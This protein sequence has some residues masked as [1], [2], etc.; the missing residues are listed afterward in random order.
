ML[1]KKIILTMFICALYTKCSFSTQITLPTEEEITATMQKGYAIRVTDQSKEEGTLYVL[2][3]PQLWGITNPAI[4]WRQMQNLDNL[5]APASEWARTTFCLKD[6]PEKADLAEGS[7]CPVTKVALEYTHNSSKKAQKVEFLALDLGNVFVTEKPYRAT[8]LM[9]SLY[10]LLVDCKET[11]L[12]VYTQKDKS[13]LE[14]KY[15][16]RN[17]LGNSYVD[18]GNS[19]ALAMHPQHLYNISLD[20]AT[21]SHIAQATAVYEAKKCWEDIFKYEMIKSCEDLLKCEAKKFPGDISKQGFIKLDNSVKQSIN[22]MGLDY[23]KAKGYD[24]TETYKAFQRNVFFGTPNSLAT[25][26]KIVF[27]QK[28]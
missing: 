3:K 13:P 4:R 8:N 16:Y 19:I 12:E 22:V 5:I 10:K 2:A 18:L 20:S 14:L 1:Y 7:I 25:D 21:F 28:I 24:A 6:I 23:V 15:C 17:E 27:S 9:P 11:P 26:A